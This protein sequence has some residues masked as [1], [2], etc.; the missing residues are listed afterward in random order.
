MN[1]QT[2]EETLDNMRINQQ[3]IE[4]TRDAIRANIEERTFANTVY[5]LETPDP[6][7]EGRILEST[8]YG[9]NT[10]QKGI[11]PLGVGAEH[12]E[13]DVLVALGNFLVQEKPIFI[14]IFKR[15]ANKLLKDAEENERTKCIR[16]LVTKL[17]ESTSTDNG[18]YICSSNDTERYSS[19]KYGSILVC[20]KCLDSIRDCE[21]CK[22]IDV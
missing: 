17:P 8:V 4:R 11:K 6:D 5:A 15:C 13:L 7:L 18:C 2:M 14:T 9:I 3:I 22:M 20:V 12:F 21:L 1:K 16:S 10:L 19:D